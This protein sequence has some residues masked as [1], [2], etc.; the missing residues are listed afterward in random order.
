M[1]I[2][3][4][5]YM[6]KFGRERI[7]NKDIVEQYEGLLKQIRNEIKAFLPDDAPTTDVT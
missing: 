3:P 2:T 6:V 5:E 7:I 1:V 4:V